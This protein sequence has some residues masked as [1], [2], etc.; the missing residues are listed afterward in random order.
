MAVWCVALLS[1]AACF[2]CVRLDCRSLLC[3]SCSWTGACTVLLDA[4]VLRCCGSL[5]SLQA[6]RDLHMLSIPSSACC[7]ST[8]HSKPIG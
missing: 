6:D 5:L 2:Y 7:R 8:E 3:L 1:L 4:L